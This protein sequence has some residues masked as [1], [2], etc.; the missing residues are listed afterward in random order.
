MLR[1]PHT[2][3]P[4]LSGVGHHMD[5]AI[6]L[7]AGT[8]D[9]KAVV[10]NYLRYTGLNGFRGL[11]RD[12]FIEIR[13]VVLN[14]IVHQLCEGLRFCEECLHNISFFVFGERVVDDPAKAP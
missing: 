11:V 10:I 1:T 14:L 4:K 5:L 2:I 3:F 12:F 13:F 7:D 8:Q 9:I 6:N